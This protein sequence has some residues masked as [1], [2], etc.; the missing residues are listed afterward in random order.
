M[1]VK[2][3]QTPIANEINCCV[4]LLYVVQVDTFLVQ[5]HDI[6]D[7]E[8]LLIRSSGGGLGAAWHL[9]KV[10]VLDPFSGKDL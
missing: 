7:I 5:C 10:E 9:S 1:L 3:Y 2:L 6:G 4:T 8:R